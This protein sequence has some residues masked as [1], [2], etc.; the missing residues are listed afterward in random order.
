MP[1][2]EE[3]LGKSLATLI[4]RNVSTLKSHLG[5]KQVTEEQGRW[6]LQTIFW[7]V[8]GKILRDKR[9]GMFEDLNLS[10]VEEV[11]KRLAKHYGTDP[12]E[13]GSTSK[14]DGLREAAHIIGQFSSLALTTTESLAYVYENTL[15]SKET[16]SAL[17]TH[18]TPSFLV[19]YI[20][21]NLADWVTEIPVNERS[22]FEPACGHAAFLVSAMRLLAEKL[23]AEKITA[24]RGP[25]LRSRLHGTDRDSFALELARLSLTLT[26]IPN[27]DGWDLRPQDMFLGDRLAE[28]AKGNTILLAN[29][30]VDI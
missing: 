4:E 5:W 17:G 7:L 8:S 6:L 26:D 28:Q 27:P 12:I 23:G 3:E 1:L 19:D 16:R 18:S 25:Y 2:L 20:V 13:V 24:R 30:S 22:V 29:P 9:V 10:N 14:L 21:G 11:F 15:I